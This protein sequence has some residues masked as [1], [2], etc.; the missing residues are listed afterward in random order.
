MLVLLTLWSILV[1]PNTCK[2]LSAGTVVAWQSTLCLTSISSLE[3]FKVFFFSLLPCVLFKKGLFTFTLHPTPFPVP[4]P[5]T[6]LGQF[7]CSITFYVPH[8]PVLC[9]LSRIKTDRNLIQQCREH[10][11][12]NI[13]GKF[14]GKKSNLSQLPC[15]VPC[16]SAC[17]WLVSALPPAGLS[18]ALCPL[19]EF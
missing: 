1:N 9:R 13:F 8:C 17:P 5:H 18:D 2:P 15:R 12:V 4:L 16:L 6:V 19:N 3:I 14:S 7:G 10:N 11:S